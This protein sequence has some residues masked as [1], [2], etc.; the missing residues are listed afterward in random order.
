VVSK[1]ALLERT[2]PGQWRTWQLPSAVMSIAGA[3]AHVGLWLRTKKRWWRHTP[4]GFFAVDGGPKAGT[5]EIDGQG[6]AVIANEQGV[7][8]LRTEAPPVKP[9]LSWNKDISPIYTKS[10]SLCHSNKGSAV[11]KLYSA[12]LWQDKYDKILKNVVSG[13]MPLKPLDPLSPA[14]IAVIKAWAKDGYLE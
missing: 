9:K 11:T 4:A 14:Q 13:A 6:N 12:K 3:S 7:H 5:L 8:R 1:G 10:C 2:A